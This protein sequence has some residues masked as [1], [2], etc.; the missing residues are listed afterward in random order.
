MWMNNLKHG[1]GKMIYING[2][3][4]EGN[5]EDGDMTGYGTYYYKNSDR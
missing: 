2:D 1:F 3:R 4:Y 5:F